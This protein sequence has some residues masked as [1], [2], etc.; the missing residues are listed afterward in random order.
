MKNVK[1]KIE[2]LK[3]DKSPKYKYNKCNRII[4]FKI[5]AN[6]KRTGGE[7]MSSIE[8]MK[9]IS[10]TEEQADKI[11]KD[12]VQSAKQVVNDANRKAS[13]II[14]DAEEQADAEYRSAI[15]KAE[16]EAEEMYNGILDKTSEKCK[17]ILAEADEKIA[18]GAKVVL[19]RIVKSNVNS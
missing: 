6:F 8:L 1:C 2:R 10:E 15:R 16:K 4:I 17:V 12:G 13:F 5:L 3:I 14:S 11:R 18:A 19:E 9:V 7:E